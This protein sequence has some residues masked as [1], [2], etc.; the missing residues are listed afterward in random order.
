MVLQYVLTRSIL[1][2]KALEIEFLDIWGFQIHRVFAIFICRSL[3]AIYNLCHFGV[4]VV[5]ILMFAFLISSNVKIHCPVGHPVGSGCL[6]NYR[7]FKINYFKRCF[8]L[9]PDNYN[10]LFIH[11]GKKPPGQHSNHHSGVSNQIAN[12]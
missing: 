1:H 10:F 8:H 9:K 6:S 7:V 4:L 2:E 11:S 12:F 5:C 3:S